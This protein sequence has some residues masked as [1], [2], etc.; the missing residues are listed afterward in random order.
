MTL[1]DDIDRLDLLRQQGALSESE[2]REA[3]QRLLAAV[4]PGGPTAQPPIPTPQPSELQAPLTPR[5]AGPMAVAREMGS[6]GSLGASGRANP[7][8]GALIALSVVLYVLWLLLGPEQPSF[9]AFAGPMDYIMWVS[10]WLLGAILQAVVAGFYLASTKTRELRGAGIA[11][12]LLGTAIVFQEFYFSGSSGWLFLLGGS[13]VL[14]LVG[15][16][17]WRQ[18]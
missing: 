5:P 9:S 13:A 15:P 4:G 10:Y 18:G 2:F 17:L 11:L 14:G 1:A 6:G 7:V 12:G 8:G 3:K 16:F